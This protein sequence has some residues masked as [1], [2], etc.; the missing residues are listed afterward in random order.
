[1]A[2]EPT[3]DDERVASRAELLP[4]EE[5]AGSDDPEAQARAILDESDERQEPRDAA[6]RAHVE[7]RTSDEV[8]TNEPPTG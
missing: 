6:P 7:H 3:A 8:T 5:T 1:M 2:D 4:E